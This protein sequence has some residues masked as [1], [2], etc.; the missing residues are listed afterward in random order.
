MQTIPARC[1]YIEVDGARIERWRERLK[2]SAGGLKVGLAWA[3]NPKFALDRLR[4]IDLPA[5]APLLRLPGVAWYSL[6]M[7]TPIDQL[8]AAVPEAA[9]MIDTTADQT[10]LA[11]TAALLMSLDL[12]ISVDTA[13]ANLA[14]ALG[15]E[16]WALL[17]PYAD[18]RWIG[19]MPD[20]SRW[21]PT[22]RIF[23]QQTRG[24]WTDV[25][26]RIASELQKKTSG[27]G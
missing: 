18:W 4:S 14:A 5:L 26:D 23:R 24:Q 16:T 19:D 21:Y 2:P 20:T 6:Q 3:G 12:V 22:S 1:P 15:R 7:G 11:E 17:S 9:T 13:I 8:K 10:D 25:I 27:T